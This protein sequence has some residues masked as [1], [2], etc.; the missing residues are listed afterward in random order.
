MTGGRVDE[1]DDAAILRDREFFWQGA[2]P[3]ATL[4]GGI[5]HVTLPPLPPTA[6]PTTVDR[7][8][9]R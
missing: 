1:D 2:G 3:A 5:L 9:R 6:W 7:D 4:S 8:G